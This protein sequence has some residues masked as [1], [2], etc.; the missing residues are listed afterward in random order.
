MAFSPVKTTARSPLKETDSNL[1]AGSFHEPV[2]E[3]QL[4]QSQELN[5]N[6]NNNNI[7]ASN[8]KKRS[9]ER[10]E[11]QQKKKTKVERTRSIEGAVLVAKPAVLKNVQSKVTPKEL[12]EW[13]NNWKKI[14]RR[15][16][17]IYFDTTED[18]S[19]NLKSKR[20]QDKK[21]ELLKRGFLSLDAQITKFFDT[22]VTIVITT[23]STENLHMLNDT[24]ILARAKKNF[25]KVWGYEKAFRFLT[26]LDVDFNAI[27]KNKTPALATPTL[28]NLL[29]NE[30]LYGPTDRDPNTKREDI[31]YFKHPYVYMYDLWQTWA[32]IITLEWRQQDLSDEENLPYPTLKMGT[33]GRCPFIGDRYCIENSARRIVKRYKRD[34][35]NYSYALKLRQLY[36]YHAL[37]QSYSNDTTSTEE[38]VF[39]P[40]ACQ[41]SASRYNVL[42]K[43]QANKIS[44]TQH[45]LDNETIKT[46]N[47]PN[48]VIPDRTEIV[49]N[50]TQ[51][52]NKPT[53]VI[54]LDNTIENLDKSIIEIK[55]H[56]ETDSNNNNSNNNND[57]KVID[58]EKDKTAWKEPITPSLKHISLV[59]L[60][61]EGTEDLQDDLCA[62]SK[63]Q[64]R[65]PFEI[66]ASGAHQSNDVATSFGNGL[67][68]TKSTVMSKNIR[69]L[70]K[71]VDRK[72]DGPTKKASNSKSA[73]NGTTPTLARGGSNLKHSFG[74]EAIVKQEGSE[75]QQKNKL[76]NNGNKPVVVKKQVVKNSGYCENCRVKYDSLEEHIVSE[77]HLNF[78]NNDFNFEA[79][80][81]LIEKLGFQF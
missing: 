74:R 66:K 13:Q 68:P 30:K 24:D 57:D 79:I 59:A 75:P 12:L 5:N 37:P 70:N 41:D 81:S 3:S 73:I 64:S 9:L 32:P 76:P 69:T 20:A 28:S 80:D 49:T 78:A 51:P 4:V 14:M 46:N 15:D 54:N 56:N 60:P 72:L 2:K 44:T 67:G 23:R 45:L 26:N 53:E 63:R 39:L 6:I 7:T 43:G 21:K 8:T 38:I 47:V 31:H 10:L 55:D 48:L 61:R 40:H 77:K 35:I 27:L 1:R 29:Q 22:S 19:D 17:R 33:F 58:L 34:Q 36:Q 52:E 16:S 42:V 18:I 71:L 25:M 65:V 11:Q 50:E 62:A